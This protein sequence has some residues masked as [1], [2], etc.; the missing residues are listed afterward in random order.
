[1]SQANWIEW[2]RDQPADVERPRPFYERLPSWVANWESWLT[3]ALVMLTFLSV[4]HSVQSAHWVSGM[5]SI[6]LVS[7]LGILAGFAFSRIHINE[8]F[9]H[10]L[11]FL[12]G[13]PI[14]V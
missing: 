9:L 4:A 11:A 1:M 5:P 13:V 10:L 3:V 14:V 6:M 8:V 2:F 7:F 12:T